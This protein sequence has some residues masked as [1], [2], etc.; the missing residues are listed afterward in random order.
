MTK[1]LK[2]ED[3]NMVNLTIEQAKLTLEI[4]ENDMQM[5]EFSNIPDFT[6]VQYMR[7]LFE[8]AS[9]ASMLKAAVNT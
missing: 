6:D 3:K 1:Q 9:L 8:R 2:Q 4:I 7:F 5:S